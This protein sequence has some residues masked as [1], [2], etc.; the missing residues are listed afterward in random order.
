MMSMTSLLLL[1][2]LSLLVHAA[3]L[4][5]RSYLTRR[6]SSC[7]SLGAQTELAPVAL[8]KWLVEQGARKDDIKVSGGQA[9]A[10]IKQSDV[11]YSV[12]MSLCLDPSKAKTLLEGIESSM[13]RTGTL[14]MLALLLLAER[15]AGTASK[16]NAYVLSLPQEI[17]GILGWDAASLEL[18]GRSTTRRVERQLQAYETDAAFLLQ[19]VQEENVQALR[20]FTAE[21]FRWA[22]GI[23]KARYFVI[24]GQPMLVPGIDSLLNDPF[25]LNEPYSASAGMF[26]GKVR[27]PPP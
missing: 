26:G 11:I 5:S 13:L 25:A 16:S 18:L 9:K 15:L 7:V 21:G 19:R 2:F 17:P 6:S 12:P 4:H 24:D 27:D 8:E 1:S 14:G 20:G 10:A 3:S 23:V 22:L